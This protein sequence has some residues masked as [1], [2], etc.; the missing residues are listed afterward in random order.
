VYPDSLSTSTPYAIVKEI[1]FWILSIGG[2][3]GAIGL[4]TARNP[5][6]CVLYSVLN[7]FCIGGLF[8]TLQAEFLAVIQIIVY[9]GAIMVLFLFVIMLLNLG[10]EDMEEAKWD[11]RRGM[12]FLLGLGFLAEMLWVVRNGLELL[13]LPAPEVYAFGKVEPIGFVL[14]TSYV[15]PFEMIS[16]ILLA[17]LIGAMVIASRKVTK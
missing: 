11:W 3:A 17:A 10:E 15:F 13:N 8:L 1:L 2:L 5:I 12:I 6:Y 9:A 7:F 16:V 4:I 14:M